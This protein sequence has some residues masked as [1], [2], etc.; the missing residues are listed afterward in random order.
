MSN[1]VNKVI[2]I[3]N[4]GD[5]V[6]IHY[7]NPTNVLARFHLATSDYYLNNE[8][9]KIIQ[10]E[11]HTIVVKNKLAEV[12]EKY[13]QKGDKI[14]VEGKL[15]TRKWDDA[16]II[17]YNTEIIV[18]RIQFLFVKKTINLNPNQ[19]EYTAPNQ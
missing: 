13:L 8:G 2:L 1:S 14:Y 7:F 11:W 6:K 18:D 16:G 12:C 5:E 9:E 19:A 10:T 4:L 15:K 3:G 17:K